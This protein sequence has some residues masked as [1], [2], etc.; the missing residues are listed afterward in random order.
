MKKLR[1]LSCV[2]VASVGLMLAGCQSGPFK[3]AAF[4][5]NLNAANNNSKGK[6]FRP[7]KTEA[8]HDKSDAS[9]YAEQLPTKRELML[10]ESNIQLILLVIKRRAPTAE[11]AAAT[12][13]AKRD[14]RNGLLPVW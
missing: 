3:T 5:S 7:S 13:I 14:V 12:Q 6:N 2:I 10:I 9:L 4:A 1:L 11:T 8:S